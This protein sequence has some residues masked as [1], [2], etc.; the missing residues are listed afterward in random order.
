MVR[1]KPF[2]SAGNFRPASEGLRRLAVRGA[3][4]T[5]LSSVLGLA[6]H[7]VSTVVLA[8]ILKP[9]D[10]GLIAMVTTFSSLL[11]NWGFN[12]ITEAIIKLEDL[13]DAL[14]SNVFWI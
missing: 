1:L 12:G 10:F 11:A 14:V 4:A 7:V 2:D 8:R 6:V 5:V 13:N 9:E 3:A